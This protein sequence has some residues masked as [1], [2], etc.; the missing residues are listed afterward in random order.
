[1]HP[2]LQKVLRNRIILLIAFLV[3]SFKTQ[4]PAQ[5]G[6]QTVTPLNPVAIDAGAGTADKPQ[7]KVFQ[8][9]DKFWAVLANSTGT[10]LYRLDGLSWTHI[11]QLTTRRGR[12]DVKVANGVV[13]VFVFQ[14]NV[15][16]LISL[17][18]VA[19]NATF[20]PWS[21]RTTIVNFQFNNQ[22]GFATIDMDGHNRMWVAY[23]RNTE[24][25][26][27]WS[28]TP[29][30]N[31][32]APITIENG[33]RSDDGAA[34][35]AMPGK[36]G[37]F[38]SNQVTQRFGFKTHLDGTSPTNWTQ[39]EQPAS[40]SALNVGGGMADDHMNMAVAGDG[41]LYCA[42]K[43]S[44]NNVN[45]PLIALLVRRPSGVWDDLYQVSNTGTTPMAILNDAQNKLKVVYAS[46]TYDA[47]ILYK[48]TATPNISFGPVHTLIGGS[49]SYRNPT[50]MKANYQTQTVILATHRLDGV[51]AGVLATDGGQVIPP[52][53]PTL[54]SP[55]NNATGVVLPPTLSWNA[56]T[57]ATSYHLQVSSNSDFSNPVY[58]T[59][60]LTGTSAEVPGLSYA[61]QYHWRVRA[62]NSAGAG[63]WS[64]R[65]FT[66]ET[67][68]VTVPPTPSLVSP[69]NNATDV[70][71]PPTLSWD[72]V[73]GA[74]SY[75]LQVSS[76]SD[77][78]NPVYN[79]DGLTGTSAEVPGLSYATQ[80]HWRVRAANSTGAG[81]WSAARAFTTETE[82]VTVPPAPSLVSPSNNATGV[83]L[84]PTLSWNAVTGATS[85]HLQVSANSDFSGS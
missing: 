64:A 75:H 25:Q 21:N 2:L 38:W 10:Q 7:S 20:V 83:V 17:Q 54:V 42:V 63:D 24:V 49:D 67:E 81:D 65:A 13:H 77:F 18:Y 32:S 62:A 37:V 3:I 56:V 74:T 8:Y 44:Y 5:E 79:T 52:S 41:T 26:V 78:S 57:G 70:V 47:E 23:V 1:M 46:Q 76:N 36:I 33:V 12:A 84:P 30:S 35:I 48:E 72:A 43:T 51:A 50:S 22:V 68:P 27:Q 55:S 15:S 16:Q 85:Y 19:S 34:V 45:H 40:Q 69:S 4:A 71:L 9:D 60:G 61:T 73:T 53:A 82:P 66:T 29:Y 6:F 14:N 31:W 39:T 11:R 58:N 59:D 80:Y 28:D